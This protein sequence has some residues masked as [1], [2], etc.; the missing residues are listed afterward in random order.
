VISRSF[1]LVRLAVNKL[2]RLGFQDVIIATD[3]GFFLNPSLEAGDVCTKPAGSWL[4]VHDRM[5]LGQSSASGSGDAASLVQPA[6]HLGLRGDFAQ[7]AVPRAMVGYSSGMSY[8]HGGLSLQE[9]L[10]PVIALR[11]KAQEKK[12]ESQ[13]KLV[14]NYKQGAKKITTRL[15]VIDVSVAGQGSFLGDEGVEFFLEAHD[16]R[17]KVVGEAKLG[18]PVNPAT[19]II[20]L[21]AGESAQITLKMDADYEGKFSVKALSP[22][23]GAT[24]GEAMAL[25]T[26]YMV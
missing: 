23:T 16:A 20:R 13:L 14:L 25:E 21:K 6:E 2:A 17:G 1:H 26:D 18:G 12:S 5:L 9:A 15:P 7:V 10:T 4:A 22:S 19:R 3:H 8:F 11:L 24:L